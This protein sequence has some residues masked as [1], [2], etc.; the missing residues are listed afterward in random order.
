MN[1]LRILVTFATC[2]GLVH[3]THSASTSE[4]AL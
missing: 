1:T 3:D 2:A 4:D